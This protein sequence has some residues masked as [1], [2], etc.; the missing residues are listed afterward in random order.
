MFLR[1]LREFPSKEVATFVALHGLNTVT[2]PTLTSLVSITCRIS[3]V[4]IIFQLAVQGVESVEFHHALVKFSSL[5]PSLSLL[6]KLDCMEPGDKA[7][8]LVLYIY[9]CLHL[10]YTL[11][12]NCNQIIYFIVTDLS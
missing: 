4:Y 3:I 10:K 8:V 12:D 11:T 9:S 5:E 1:P 7:K 2:I 6:Q